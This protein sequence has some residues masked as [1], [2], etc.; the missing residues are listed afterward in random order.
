MPPEVTILMLT[1]TSVTI[2]WTQPG[3]SLLVAEYTIS[4]E[5]VT[6]SGLCDSIVDNR[7]IK[8]ISSDN[9]TVEISHLQEFSTY[10][11]TVTATFT[12]FTNSMNSSSNNFFTLS[13][14][15]FVIQ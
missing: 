11:V 4:L 10:R 1:A 7:S 2:F 3:L 9:T 15:T 6:G 12:L 13:A 5:R 8:N 14:R